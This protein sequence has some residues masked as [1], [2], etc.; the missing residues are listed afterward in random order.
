MAA[1]NFT[2]QPYPWFPLPPP[3]KHLLLLHDEYPSTLP[4]GKMWGCV[5]YPPFFCPFAVL[6]HLE[7]YILK[8]T[9]L[10]IV[11]IE[12]QGSFSWSPHLC[13]SPLPVFLGGHLLWLLPLKS[14]RAGP[15]PPFQLPPS[16]TPFSLCSGRR[17]FPIFDLQKGHL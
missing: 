11:P 10:P 16:L 3:P 15:C 7:Y 13:L 14:S 8:A 17:V 9:L 12:L 2:F 6:C 4:V 1:T 5:T